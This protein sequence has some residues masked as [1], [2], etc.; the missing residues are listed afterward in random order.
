MCATRTAVRVVAVALRVEPADN[1]PTEE[2]SAFTVVMSIPDSAL[3]GGERPV[4]QATW[5]AR[6]VGDVPQQ[7][8]GIRTVVDQ[9]SN[10]ASIT[11]TATVRLAWYPSPAEAVATAF[12]P[13]GAVPVVVSRK[14][15]KRL[16]APVGHG[17]SLTVGT[18]DVPAE[19]VGVVPTIPSAP[20]AVAVLADVD[21][22]S[23]S[24]IASGELTPTVD[25]WW[26]G[27][28][29]RAGAQGAVASRRLGDVE[30]RTG[31]RE[32]LVRSPLRISLPATLGVLVPAALLLVFAGTLLH[33]TSDVEGRALEVARLRGLG[34]S[35]RGVLL[36]LLAQ[37]GLLLLLLVTT[38]ALVGAVA[39]ALVGPLLVTSDLGGSPVPAVVVVWPWAA[40]GIML[41]VLVA[42]C[43]TA[44]TAVVAVQ[45][46]RADAAH[47]RVGS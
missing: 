21:L 4:P 6:S 44:V 19:V 25:A 28:P 43:T 30:T 33:V 35:R 26:V 5:R 16:G 7:L 47:L 11:T 27:S 31:L 17:L 15:S 34:V 10:G 32:Q 12:P 24:L 14:L 42:G 22:L 41:A 9:G 45:V 18:K 13:L 23:R 2:P 39:S 1:V 3:D 46:R 8:T 37:H 38:G 40:L 29:R 20:G 36:S